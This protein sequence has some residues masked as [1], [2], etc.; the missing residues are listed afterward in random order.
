MTSEAGPLPQLFPAAPWGKMW[1][2]TGSTF[3]SDLR[4]CSRAPVFVLKWAGGG[5]VRAHSV[6]GRK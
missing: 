6:I 4:P 1:E 5:F 2:A 3:L